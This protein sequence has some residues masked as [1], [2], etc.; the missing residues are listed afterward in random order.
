M[1][2]GELL[3]IFT[4]DLYIG[5]SDLYIEDGAVIKLFI[6]MYKRFIYRKEWFI[7]RGRYNETIIYKIVRGGV[8]TGV[9]SVLDLFMQ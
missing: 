1:P 6:S 4:R 7:Y 9:F 5:G 3:L 8:F 2:A